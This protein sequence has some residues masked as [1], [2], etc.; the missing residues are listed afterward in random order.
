MTEQT[1]DEDAEAFKAATVAFLHSLPKPKPC[2]HDW[3][4][5]REF[6]DGSGGERVCAQCG[7]GAMAHTLRQEGWG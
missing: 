3:R 5:W 6:E 1:T 7:L 2:K 4:D